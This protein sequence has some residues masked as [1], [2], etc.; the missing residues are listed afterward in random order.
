MSKERDNLTESCLAS[1]SSNVCRAASSPIKT[2]PQKTIPLAT[3]AKFCHVVFLFFFF[4]HFF[5]FFSTFQP[6]LKAIKVLFPTPYVSPFYPFCFVFVFS[7]CLV[8]RDLRFFSRVRSCVRLYM[9]LP[10][11]PLPHY[12]LRQFLLRSFGAC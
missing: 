12:H 2:H 5:F 11:S 7:L 6:T 8:F 4:F 9:I 10:H 3:R 1:L